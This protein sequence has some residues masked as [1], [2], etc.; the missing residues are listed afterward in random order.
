MTSALTPTIISQFRGLEPY[1]GTTVTAEVEV[2]RPI[3]ADFASAE[4]ALI[5]LHASMLRHAARELVPEYFTAAA[6]IIF[7]LVR[8]IQHSTEQMPEEVVL[9]TVAHAMQSA[10]LNGSDP[11]QSRHLDLARSWLAQAYLIAGTDGGDTR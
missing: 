3:L 1:R 11:S 5:E 10:L 9:T 2:L 4:Q 7:G 6:A 8:A